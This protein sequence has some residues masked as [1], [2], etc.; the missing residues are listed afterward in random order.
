[1]KTL[2]PLVV[3]TLLA[4]SCSKRVDSPSLAERVKS[5]CRNLSS[6]MS[7]AATRY[8]DYAGWMADHRMSPEQ[9]H[10]AEMMLGYGADDM[11]RGIGVRGLQP[12]FDLCAR[13]RRLEEPRIDEIT[14]RVS[15]HTGRFILNPDPG[16]MAR[17][18][19][20]LAAIAAEIDNLPLRD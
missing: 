6:E 18:I 10:R 13:S 4:G 8:R 1:M 20:G 2:W 3:T 16:E 12:L 14:V 7:Q 19:E 11:A 17:S 9:Q 15:Q 5:T